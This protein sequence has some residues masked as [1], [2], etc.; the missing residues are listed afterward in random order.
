MPDV[1]LSDV[2]RVTRYVNGGDN[3]LA[4]RQQLTERAIEAL[5]SWEP[6]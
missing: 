4:H 5:Q 6:A 1:A 2:R 3:G